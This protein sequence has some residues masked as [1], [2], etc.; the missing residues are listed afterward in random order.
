MRMIFA[1]I[2]PQIEQLDPEERLK[3][4]AFLKHLVR[5]NNPEYQAEL[6]RRNAEMDAGQK[7]RWT[8]LKRDLGLS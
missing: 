5:A 2:K 4:L 6:A 1:E 8:D 3:A 7:V